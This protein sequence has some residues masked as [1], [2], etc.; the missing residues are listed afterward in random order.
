MATFQQEIG[1]IRDA[2]NLNELALSELEMI[3][4]FVRDKYKNQ[5]MDSQMNW[6]KAIVTV[7]L[8]LV[9]GNK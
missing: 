5:S 9:K 8:A 3:K 4:L 7:K 1:M 2:D 6:E